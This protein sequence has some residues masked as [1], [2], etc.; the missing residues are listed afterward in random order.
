MKISKGED[1]IAFVG[2]R[3]TVKVARTH[4][5]KFGKQAIQLTQRYGIRT[6]INFWT[7]FDPDQHKSLQNRLLHGVNANR[8]EERLARGAGSVVVPTVS[9]LGGIA[10]VQLTAEA[11]EL[12]GRDIRGTFTDHLGTVPVAQLSHMLE[13]PNNLGVDDG[14]IKF[15]DG[16]SK[17][18]EELI[19]SRPTEIQDSLAEIAANYNQPS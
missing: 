18:L 13:N 15:V 1:R 8:R 10:N 12:S 3:L 4:P 6:A 19:G 7:D 2:E 9:I 11:P 5:L 16:G 14:V 17:A